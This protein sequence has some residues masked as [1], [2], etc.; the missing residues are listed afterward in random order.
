MQK[1]TKKTNPTL[2]NLAQLRAR[3]PQDLA[4]LGK[5]GLVVERDN[6]YSL[7]STSL[8]RWIKQEILAAP[9]EEASQS[10]AEEW[11]RSGRHRELKPAAGLM[12][13]FKKKY[14]PIL[15]D[16]AKEL[17]FEFAAAGTME[18]I[19]LLV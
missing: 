11:V 17:S 4:A 3:A 18:L 5:R 2:E 1:A 15:G 9:G 19:K 13:R 8:G 12:P 14:W 10:S 7:F 16:L 6:L